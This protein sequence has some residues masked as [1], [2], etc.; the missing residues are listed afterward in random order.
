MEF[1]GDDDGGSD[2]DYIVSGV[3]APHY[4]TFKRSF[5]SY[6]SPSSQFESK[7]LFGKNDS[8]YANKNKVN[9]RFSINTND[10][11]EVKKICKSTPVDLRT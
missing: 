5:S 1:K 7:T 10:N 8:F 4:D 6:S 11:E 3:E 2:T 9:N